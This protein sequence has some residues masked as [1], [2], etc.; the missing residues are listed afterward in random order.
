MEKVKNSL[1]CVIV[2]LLSAC[3]NHGP[4][5]PDAWDLTE[6]Q[7]DSLSFFTTHHY[8]QN[9]NFVVKASQMPISDEAGSQAFDTLYVSKGDPLVVADIKTIS[10]DTIDSV[11]VK[12]ARDQMTQGWIRES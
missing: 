6:R 11:W 7:I 4:V 2:L 1:L 3:Y 5:S 10:S 12:V 9:Y 8:S